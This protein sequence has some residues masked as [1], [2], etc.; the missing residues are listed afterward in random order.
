M[1]HCGQAADTMS[2]SSRRQ[3]PGGRGSD[4]QEDEDG[5]RSR[6]GDRKTEARHGPAF[7][8]EVGTR[9]SHYGRSPAGRPGM[10]AG[11]G[12][13]TTG[14]ARKRQVTELTTFGASNVVGVG[15]YDTE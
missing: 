2:R 14:L 8:R 12:I 5:D 11:R 3:L 4:R 13:S 15:R 1:W 9:T 6:S 7:L 10:R